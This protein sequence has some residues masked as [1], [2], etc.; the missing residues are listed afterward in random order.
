M[1]LA[2]FLDAR[3]KIDRPVNLHVT[4]CPHSC[5]QH[6]I[7]DIGLLGTKV[8]GEEGYQVVIGGGS[9]HDQGIARELISSI[10]FSDLSPVMERLFEAYMSQ[11]NPEESFL[12]FTR[13]HSISDLQGFCR[14]QELP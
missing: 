7:G 1:E 2:N 14:T 6:Y 3:F 12:N 10:P 13:R 5:A 8:G 4:G 9:D 11:S